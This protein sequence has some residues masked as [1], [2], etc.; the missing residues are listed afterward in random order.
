VNADAPVQDCASRDNQGDMFQ[1]RGDVPCANYIVV[2][3]EQGQYSWSLSTRGIVPCAVPCSP[4]RE[5]QN[6]DRRL[7]GYKVKIQI[8]SVR[9]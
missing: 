3:A 7:Q 2:P 4:V 1:G 9:I 6:S 8:K 5:A